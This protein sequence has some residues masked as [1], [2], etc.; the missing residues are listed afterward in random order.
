MSTTTPNYSFILPAVNDPVDANVWGTQ[1]NANFSNLDT[2]LKLIADGASFLDG[3]FRINNTTDATKK[4][5]F[6]VSTVTTATTRT[7]T[8]QD[9]SGTIYVSGGTDVAIADGGT[10]S[11]TALAG[12]DNLK[13]QSTTSYTGVVE[14][15]TNAEVTTGTDTS[16]I[17]PVSAMGSHLGMVQ[18]WA[19]ASISG[20]ILTTLDSYG[21]TIARTGTG[22]FTVTFSSAF[23]NANYIPTGST[24]ITSGLLSAIY[25]PSGGTKSTAACQLAV[26]AAGGG[27]SDPTQIYVQFVGRR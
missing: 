14:L 26:D 25:V 9:V 10:G 11:G 5:A 20:G 13:Q 21:C 4:L 19:S 6:D 22:R 23:A 3:T 24:Q 7:L 18:A 16:R 1:L 12:F 8:I 17:A 27:A 15:A 2:D